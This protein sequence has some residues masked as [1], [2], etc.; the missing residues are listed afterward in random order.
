[1]PAKKKTLRLTAEKPV[2]DHM[3]VT[4][5]F[6][7]SKEDYHRLLTK[8]GDKT[9]LT[10]LLDRIGPPAHVDNFD[11]WGSLK[12]ETE[13]WRAGA[14]MVAVELLFFTRMRSSFSFL[15]KEKKVIQDYLNNWLEK[16]PVSE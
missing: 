7:V 6:N 14:D 4:F 12:D 1:M 11:A 8:T 15:R 16:N 13:D 5:F 9:L 10:M 3:R 2:E